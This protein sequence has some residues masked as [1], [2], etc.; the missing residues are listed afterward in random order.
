MA[1]KTLFIIV[2]SL[3]Y[4]VV[5]AQRLS[6]P[7]M[8]SDHMVIQR[9]KPIRVWGK[10]APGDWLH[11]QFGPGTR[12]SPALRIQGGWRA[13]RPAA[14]SVDTYCAACRKT[15]GDVRAT[16]HVTRRT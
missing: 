11:R 9:D 7:A 4:H 3:L 2:A 5:L 1:I 15:A 14:L 12:P 10:A 13:S 8:Y 16:A 6:L